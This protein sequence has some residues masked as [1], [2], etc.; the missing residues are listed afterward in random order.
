MKIGIVSHAR[1]VWGEEGYK[2]LAELGYSAIDFDIICSNNPVFTLSD[3]EVEKYL[4]HQKDLGNFRPGM[5]PRR[6]AQS[7]WT[8]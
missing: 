4:D 1:D 8:R 3:E 6:N 2:K 5:A 7:A